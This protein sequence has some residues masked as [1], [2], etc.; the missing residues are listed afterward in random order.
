MANVNFPPGNP[1][2]PIPIQL[3]STNSDMFGQVR[4]TEARVIFE[5]DGARPLSQIRDVQNIWAGSATISD[6]N[7][8]E[9]RLRHT[10]GSD[11]ASLLSAQRGRY[12]PGTVGE[13][14]IGIRFSGTI[15]NSTSYA[16]WGYFDEDGSGD[17]RDGIL[18]GLDSVGTYV[19]VVRGGSEVFKYYR[20]GDPSTGANPW[21]QNRSAHLEADSDNG[22]KLYQFPFVYYGYG[23]VNFD[24]LDTQQN[25]GYLRNT[26]VHAYR[27]STGTIFA[28]PNLRVGARVGSTGGTDDFSLYIGGRK[29]VLYGDT[30]TVKRN[31]GEAVFGYNVTTTL[32]PVMTFRTKDTAN[33]RT[34]VTELAEVDAIAASEVVELQ[35]RV[36]STL[37]T[38]SFVTPSDTDATETA[39]EVDTTATTVDSSSGVLV[40]RTLLEAGNGQ[41][42]AGSEVTLPRFP[43]PENTNVTVAA[44]TFQNTATLDVLVQLRE[45]W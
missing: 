1:Y 10:T 6:T 7:E 44:K 3:V 41:R 45:S 25:L 27:S 36:N 35:I 39:I 26:T 33:F 21:N 2:S 16:E 29:F 40:Y 20:E 42:V 32:T 24:V 30:T 28:N 17:V 34:I 4:M 19:R 31:T 23:G 5:L 43:I 9:Y 38:A 11:K 37:D 12:V 22:G 15:S 8:G 13:A 14:G 18:M